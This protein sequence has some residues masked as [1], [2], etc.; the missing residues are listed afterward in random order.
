MITEAYFTLCILSLKIHKR[1][2]E[3]I[4]QTGLKLNFKG[5]NCSIYWL[6]KHHQLFIKTC[7]YQQL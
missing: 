2:Y 4:I 7:I 6:G 1:I 5:K 3:E